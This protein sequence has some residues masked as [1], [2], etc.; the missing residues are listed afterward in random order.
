MGSSLGIVRPLRQGMLTFIIYSS[1]CFVT[2]KLL[3]FP[4]KNSGFCTVF[5]SFFHNRR[6]RIPIFRL[7]YSTI[8]SQTQ[9]EDP[10]LFEKFT[11]AVQYDYGLRFSVVNRIT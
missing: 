3:T 11:K 9:E 7:H 8:S 10:L 5:L 1:S 6:Q 2:E 4:P